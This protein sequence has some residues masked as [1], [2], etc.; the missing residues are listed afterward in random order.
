[1]SEETSVRSSPQNE[2]VAGSKLTS[3][4]EIERTATAG[5]E[6]RVPQQRRRSASDGSACSPLARR[7]KDKERQKVGWDIPKG[8]LAG[9]REE[10]FT[11]QF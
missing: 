9:C 7:R 10:A 5:E 2:V 11:E 8:D 3:T 6:L 4:M 1:M